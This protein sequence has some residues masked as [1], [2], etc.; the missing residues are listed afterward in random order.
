MRMKFIVPV[1]LFF[2]SACSAQP[3]QP[4]G[5]IYTV[6][7]STQKAAALQTESALR[8]ARDTA[9]PATLLPTM[10]LEA[11]PTTYIYIRDTATPTPS[12]TPTPR[13]VTVFPDWKT[14]SVIKVGGGGGGTYKKFNELVGLEVM[15]VRTGGVKLRSTP[16]KAI[17]GPLEEKGSVFK[18]T[19]I[20]NKN[21][22]QGW[23]FVQVIAADGNKY[24]VGGTEGD[25]NAEPSASLIFYYPWLTPSPTPSNT[26]TPTGTPAP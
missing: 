7:A 5:F 24:W 22:K 23:L 8:L 2:L 19:G 4:P 11:T 21:P 10:T 9:T 1:L 13:L 26:P 25:E 15:V 16:N 3:A 6:V 20:M 17:G 12:L 14:G 18:L